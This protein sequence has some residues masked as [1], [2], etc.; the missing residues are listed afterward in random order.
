MQQ[1]ILSYD[2]SKEISEKIGL[3]TGKILSAAGVPVFFTLS[4]MFFL[5]GT[6]QGREVARILTDPWDTSTGFR[7]GAWLV[8]ALLVWAITTWNW[9]RI[10]LDALYQRPDETVETH[11]AR[12]DQI[13][14]VFDRF[15]MQRLPAALACTPSGWFALVAILQGV[16][17]RP[18]WLSFASLLLLSLAICIGIITRRKWLKSTRLASITF[19]F[20]AHIVLILPLISFLG[21]GDPLY[22][23][24]IV[25]GSLFLAVAV[26]ALFPGF[27]PRNTSLWSMTLSARDQANQFTGNAFLDWIVKKLDIRA[28]NAYFLFFHFLILNFGGAVAF[29]FFPVT[30]GTFVGPAAVVA[31][32]FSASLAPFCI[33][34]LVARRSELN[35]LLLIVLLVL[36]SGLLRSYVIPSE[37]FEI[38]RF[39]GPITDTMFGR[40]S[41]CDVIRRPTLVPS[42][43]STTNRYN[44]SNCDFVATG[45]A[46]IG[47]A[48]EKEPVLK[49]W[50]DQWT[51]SVSKRQRA[52]MP[53]IFVSSSGGGQKAALWTA[54]VLSTIQD[55]RDKN[56][57]KQCQINSINPSTEA[58]LEAELRFNDTLFAISSVSGGTW[59]TLSYTGLIAQHPYEDAGF[60]SQ[61]IS[62]ILRTDILSPILAS[63]FFSDVASYFHPA[64]I[65]PVDR[66]TAMEKALERAWEMRLPG[67]SNSRPSEDPNCQSGAL[68]GDSFFCLWDKNSPSWKPALLINGAHRQTGKRIITS[69]VRLPEGD[70][71][72]LDFFEI[73]DRNIRTSTAVLN[74][75][76]FPFASP[77]GLVTNK[78]G[79]SFGQILDGGY[80]DNYGSYTLLDV[81]RPVLKNLASEETPDFRYRPIFIEIANDSFVQCRGDG[82]VGYLGASARNAL[83]PKV[84]LF[85]EFLAPISGYM[86]AN[87]DD[88]NTAP[89]E[90]VEYAKNLDDS[91]AVSGSDALYLQFRLCDVS[92]FDT[93][94]GWAHSLAG[95]QVYSRSIPINSEVRSDRAIDDADEIQCLCANHKA[96]HDLMCALNEST[97]C[98]D[99]PPLASKPIGELD[100]TTS[101]DICE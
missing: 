14:N 38:R 56:I 18:K 33:I 12:Y 99:P 72:P 62:S 39:G 2:G 41:D 51:S 6:S 42:P 70:E 94:L 7:H 60:Y 57:I 92:D 11:G 85:D 21:F 44:H 78:M 1:A 49:S 68:F 5:A 46:T 86:N 71:G 8:S 17:G 80:V 32:A 9:T 27:F 54:T 47:G 20:I 19:A 59:G 15:L 40:S 3:S 23:V 13:S 83:A 61:S 91:I 52:D 43:V 37:R 22:L 84:G 25:A 87:A 24:P 74:S 30:A 67:T 50:L 55:E 88:P 76:R 93:P 35:V 81:A 73:A 31:F 4:F 65:H 100:F 29:G 98:G 101:D 16:P 95:E 97:D 90:V 26:S 79:D 96:A 28:I 75:A 64:P 45:E 34:A 53:I 48:L 69:N 10:R 66:A 77:P 89:D 63:L 36:V 58:C 82:C